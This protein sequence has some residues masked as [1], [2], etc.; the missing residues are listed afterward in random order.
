MTL[1]AVA[2]RVGLGERRM[3]G[4]AGRRSPAGPPFAGNVLTSDQEQFAWG[5]AQV[6]RHPELALGPPSIGWTHAAF[7]ETARLGAKPMPDVPVLVL[8]G[9]R[10]IVVSPPAIRDWAGRMPSCDLLELEGGRHEVFMERPE[11][12][13][14]AWRRIDAFLAETPSFK[15]LSVAAEA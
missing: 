11:I 15:G 13:S 12:R 2:G 4:T 8:L 5:V 1:A 3:P 9:S 10:E 14:A 7:Q 6:M